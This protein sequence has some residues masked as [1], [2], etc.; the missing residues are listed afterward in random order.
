M[1]KWDRSNK[2]QGEKSQSGGSDDYDPFD[3]YA[4]KSIFNVYAISNFA[5]CCIFIGELVW[6][7]FQRRN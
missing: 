5:G 4:L 7:R 6:K 3:L 2:V 1:E